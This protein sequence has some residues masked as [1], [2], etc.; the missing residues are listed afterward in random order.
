MPAAIP[1]NG[2]FEPGDK[3]KEDGWANRSKRTVIRNESKE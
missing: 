3:F 2:R 1:E